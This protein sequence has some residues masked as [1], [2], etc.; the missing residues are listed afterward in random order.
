MR[1]EAGGKDPETPAGQ[2]AARACPARWGSSPFI[3][4]EPTTQKGVDS[5][6]RNNYLKTE[7]CL[8]AV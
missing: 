3:G 5:V 1:P 6:A 4:S 2:D 8:A 7:Y